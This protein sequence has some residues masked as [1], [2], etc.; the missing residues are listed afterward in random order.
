M[1]LMAAAALLSTAIAAVGV[2][3]GAIELGALFYMCTPGIAGIII[4]WLFLIV[5]DRA[6]RYRGAVLLAALI[7][8]ILV[9]ILLRLD[10][11]YQFLP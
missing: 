10:F 2:N 3:Y 9:G 8:N 6:P 1:L 4:I 7:T 5:A 11:Y